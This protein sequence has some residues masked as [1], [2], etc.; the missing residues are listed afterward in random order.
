MSDSKQ[1]DIFSR[2]DEAYL[3]SN[4]ARD[5]MNLV[6]V[7]L[8]IVRPGS[9]RR[10]K[11][12]VVTP[13]SPGERTYDIKL[14][15]NSYRID[16]EASVLLPDGS[17]ETRQFYRSVE[18]NRG[19][20]GPHAEDIFIALLKLTAEKHFDED[21]IS[22]TCHQ[23][24]ELMQWNKTKYY[25]NRLRETLHQLV[26][27]SVHT[28]AIWHPEKKRYVERAF[29][30]F[31]D[32]EIDDDSRH[33]DA[34]CYVRWAKGVF[35][36]FQMGYTKPLDTEF[37]YSLEDPMSKRM[38]RWLDKH[39]RRSTIV[40]IDVLEFAQKVL[41]YGLSYQ[42]PSEV[43]RKLEPKLNDLYK[44]GFC[45][46]ETIIDANFASRVKY[47]FYRVTPY[48]SVVYPTREN[49]LAALV[50]RQV[51]RETAEELID[52][53]GWEP[54]LRQIDHLDYNISAGEAPENPGGWLKRAIS[55]NDG[56]GFKLPGEL[57][58]V[59]KNARVETQRWCAE[60]YEAMSPIERETLK[61]E[62]LAS[63]DTETRAL[64]KQDN[65]QA[66]HR[67]LK[68]RNQRLLTLRREIEI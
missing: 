7:V 48:T 29:N 39:L 55:Y 64:L 61:Q 22:L 59:I 8:G 62:I 68:L 11:G 1:L 21:K 17:K 40:E 36:L 18:C 23:L 27:M 53:H 43:T 19:L 52:T 51:Y 66:H 57:E 30:I 28:N 32:M 2:L 26:G 33:A 67:F 3:T 37:F 25:Y 58:D 10:K 46:W 15:E 41:G 45:R 42:Y 60:M 65:S 14:T 50:E 13:W 24:L 16:W 6:E 9:G 54:C 56:K 35:E 31:S 34:G 38:Y 47:A 63:A 20:P 5:D 12:E 49:I 4:D 44:R